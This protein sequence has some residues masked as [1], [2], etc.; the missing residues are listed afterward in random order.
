MDFLSKVNE[1][2]EKMIQD[3]Q[4][5]L[6]IDSTLIEN[7]DSKEAP[8]GEGIRQSLDYL[9]DLGEKMGFAVKNVNNVS[10][11]IEYGE[12]Q[13]IVGILV[14]VDVVPAIGKWK[15]PPFSAT[16]EGNKLYARGANDDKGPAIAALYALKALKDLGVKLNKRVRLIIGTDEETSW[17]GIKEYFKVCEMPTVGFSPDAEFP[18]IY[19][20]KGI[21]SIDVIDEAPSDLLF[22]AG[23]RYNVVPDEARVRIDKDLQ[24]EFHAF[25]EATGLSGEYGDEI[26]LHGK[27]AHAMEP[28]NGINAMIRLCEFL[29]GHVNN[30]LIQ[31]VADKLN[32]SRFKAI[33]LDFSD[34]EMKDLTVN[35]A[36]LK[37]DNRQ[38]KLGLNLRYPI[39]WDKEAF[40]KNFREQAASYGLNC[41]IRSDQVPHYVDK[42]DPLVKTLHN[43]Y[44]EYTGD[45]KSE[46]L[47]IGGGTY[48]RALKKG[49]AFGVVFPGREEVAHQVDEYV[50]IED[51]LLATAIMTK[52]IYDLAK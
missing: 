9:L 30:S 40:L 34:P 38:G 37:I 46:L 47:T 51:I 31:F 5:L 14:H 16:I 27:A 12:G 35:A 7:P 8:F 19:G 39:N 3:M 15:Y 22:A 49:V 20:E 33:G 10:G 18:V 21:M 36:V 43:A 50:I 24:K 1:N 29:S 25:L 23:D 6:R 32:D 11:H 26:I 41:L 28:N 48:A 13:D 4:G 44:I 52:A 17:R 45:T 2:K 42:N